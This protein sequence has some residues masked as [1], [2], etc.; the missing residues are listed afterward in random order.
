LCAEAARKSIDSFDFESEAALR[1]PKWPF[2][3]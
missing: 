2:T 3:S 1:L